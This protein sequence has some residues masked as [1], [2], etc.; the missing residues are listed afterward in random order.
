MFKF[1]FI[2]GAGRCG[3]NLI[4]GLLDG[5]PKIDVLSGEPTNYFGM[6]LRHNGMSSNVNFALSGLACPTLQRRRF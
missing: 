6:V 5:H 3:T 4:T 1:I 2:T